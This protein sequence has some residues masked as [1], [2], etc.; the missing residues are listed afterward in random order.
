MEPAADHIYITPVVS[1]SCT[2][3]CY[4]NALPVL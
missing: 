1:L 2:T 3:A 4:G